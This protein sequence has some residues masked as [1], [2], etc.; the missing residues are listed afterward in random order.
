MYYFLTLGYPLDNGN[1]SVLR[2]VEKTGTKENGPV[3]VYWLNLVE[4]P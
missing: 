4:K 2:L 3:F 1:S